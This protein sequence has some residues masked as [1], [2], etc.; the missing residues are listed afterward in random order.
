MSSAAVTA[1]PPNGAM[2]ITPTDL[3]TLL[4]TVPLTVAVTDDYIV[5]ASIWD[6]DYSMVDGMIVQESLIAG[7]RNI[8]IEFSL[9]SL[10]RYNLEGPYS[11]FITLLDKDENFLFNRIEYVD[12]LA[13]TQ[14]PTSIVFNSL[15]YSAEIPNT[16]ITTVATKAVVKDQYGQIMSGLIPTYTVSPAYSGVTVNNTTGVV[17]ISSSAGAGTVSIKAEYGTLYAS[18]PLEITNAAVIYDFRFSTSVYQINNLMENF[19]VSAHLTNEAGQLVNTPILYTLTNG[20]GGVFT[21]TTGLFDIECV[22]SLHL[23]SVEAEAYYYGEKITAQASIRYTI[24][25]PSPAPV[26]PEP[27]IIVETDRVK[28]N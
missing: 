27:K 5:A 14:M 12:D 13:T 15:S 26:M 20:I 25:I 7:S 16:G 17:T 10:F 21:N 18:V 2:N 6:E 8:D 19:T 23:L 4:V 1:S 22:G 3:S 24:I 11:I 28:T 9:D